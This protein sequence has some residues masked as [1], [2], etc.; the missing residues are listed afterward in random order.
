[1]TAGR[2]VVVSTV[3]TLL[4]VGAVA[5]CGGGDDSSTGA[6]PESPTVS[7]SPTP[8]PGERIEVAGRTAV[9]HGTEDVS[10]TG[11]A[12]IDM[13]DGYFSP[14]VL[15]GKPG[16]KLE[17]TLRNRGETPHHFTTADQQLIVEVQPG[18]TAEGRITLPASGNL[19]FYCTLHAEHGMAGAFHVSGSVAAPGPEATQTR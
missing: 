5:A 19:S 12:T 18:L 6:G 17:L 2:R 7:A 1:M 13:V 3:V 4:S 11:R 14:T 9:Y 10:G 16:Q 15:K 8:S